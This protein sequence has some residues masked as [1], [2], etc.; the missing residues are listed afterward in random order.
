MSV[1][2]I[3][4]DLAELYRNLLNNK[5]ESIE[6][7]NSMDFYLDELEKEAAENREKIRELGYWTEE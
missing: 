1:K 2:K 3:I 6:N 7:Q 4:S 5:Q